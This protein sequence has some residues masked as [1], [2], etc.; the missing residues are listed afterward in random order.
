MFGGI[1]YILFLITNYYKVLQKNFYRIL[2][3][4]IL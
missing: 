4:L 1:F 2:F 3:V